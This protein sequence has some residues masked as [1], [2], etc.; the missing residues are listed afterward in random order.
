VSIKAVGFDMG[1]TLIRYPMPKSWLSNYA[2]A[3]Q[4]TARDCGWTL[5]PDKT[6]AGIRILTR[7]N[8]R[9]NPREFEVADD[10]IFRE[11][12]TA[13]GEDAKF[14]G[15]AKRSFF[16]FFMTGAEPFDDALPALKAVKALGLKT[17]LY[18]NVAYGMENALSLADA[19]PLEGYL[20]QLQTSVDVGCLKPHPRGYELLARK[21]GVF[22]EEML[23]VGDEERDVTGANRAGAVSVLLDREGTGAAY[24]QRYTIRSLYELVEI[25][26]REEGKADA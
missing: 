5:N 10:D 16:A 6:D 18:T 19:A 8:T 13:W 24:G 2:P 26:K 12:L 1:H 4:K 20:D 17:G 7:Y 22:P 11:I 23:F 9:V 21:L 25:L 15:Q 3:L 14:V